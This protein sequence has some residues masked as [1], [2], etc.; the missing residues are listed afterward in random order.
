MTES[1]LTIVI[2]AFKVDFLVKT[3]ESIFRQTDGRF[4]LFIGFDSNQEEINSILERYRAVYTFESLDFGDGL[5]QRDLV[6]HWNRCVA[7]SALSEWV[8]LFSDDDVMHEDC[9]KSF[10]EELEVSM[11]QDLFHFNVE[12]IDPNDVILT[13]PHPFPAS[14][15]TREY[16][17]LRAKGIIES[18][19][20]EYIFRRSLFESMGRFVKFDLAWCSDD[21]TW[22]G[23]SIVSGIRTI[24]GPGV[25]WRRSERNITPAVSS[26]LLRRKFA[27]E[28]AYLK[29]ILDLRIDE[30]AGNAGTNI[31]QLTLEWFYRKMRHAAVYMSTSDIDSIF[32]QLSDLPERSLR[33]EWFRCKTHFYRLYFKQKAI[34]KLLVVKG[35]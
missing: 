32:D 18:F 16:V 34:G 31:F 22:I 26:Q 14:L 4:N 20:I 27:S 24:S 33:R 23:L 6:A 29:W 11:N 3:L 21:A 8:W 15:T 28:I 7:S 2:P 30:V 9:V 13:R 5:S 10:Y 19:V 1:R 25:Y 12:I 17:E 35:A